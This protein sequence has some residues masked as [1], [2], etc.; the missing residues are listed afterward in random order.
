MKV[1]STRNQNRERS[2][3]IAVSQKEI[4][5]NFL[6]YSGKWTVTIDC[7]N[8]YMLMVSPFWDY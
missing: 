6:M 3:L 2:S 8:K 1:S 7:D 5:D 4:V